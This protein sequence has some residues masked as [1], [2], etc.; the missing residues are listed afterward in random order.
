MAIRGV[1]L[2]RAVEALA[3]AFPRPAKL[4]QLLEYRLAKRLDALVGPGGTLDR[5]FDLFQ[6]ANSE[7]WDLELLDAA[8]A[9]NPGHQGLYAVAQELALVPAVPAQL[10]ALISTKNRMLD[11]AGWYRRLGA[12]LPCVCRIELDGKP[13]GSGFLVG[14]DLVLTNDHVI[15]PPHRQ[16]AA[17]FDHPSGERQAIPAVIARVTEILDRSPPSAHDF[18]PGQRGEATAD[19]LDYALLRLERPLGA[20]PIGAHAD[21]DAPMRGW[22]DI[23]LS[24]STTITPGMPLVIVQHPL[25]GPMALAFDTNGMLGLNVSGT[26]VRYRNNTE[27]GSSGSPCFDQ[28]WNPVALHQS[29]GLHKPRPVFNQGI[30]L[31]AIAARIAR[32]TAITLVPPER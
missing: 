5:I 20:E 7:G 30:P 23:T 17:R 16:I 27:H 13:S 3:D 2:K 28:D 19:E 15:D 25:G 22:L 12:T 11:A 21:P 32:T 18:D 9:T 10:E 24:G 14:A 31:S 26:R 4:E 8:R 1:Q 29:S 6:V